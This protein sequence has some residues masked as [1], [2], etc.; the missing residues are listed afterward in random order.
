MLVGKPGHAACFGACH[1]PL[2]VA[3]ARG[4]KIVTGDRTKVCTAC[5][6]E[7]AARRA[8]RRQ[9]A[10]ALPAVQDRSRTSAS[11]LGHKQ[12]AQVACTQC[13]APSVEDAP[14]PH[15]RCAGCHDGS[16]PH[17]RW[18]RARAAT[19]RR[20]A[21]RSRPSSPRCTTRVT[22]I[23]LARHARASAARRTARRATPRSR[24]PTTASCLA[25]PSRTARRCHDG[26]AA[27]ATT[28]A[29]RRCHDRAGRAVHG[30]RAP[31][32]GSATT[33]RTPRRSQRARAARAIRCR[34]P[35]RSA[36]PATRRARA[37]TPMTSARASRR[38]AAR[39]TTRPSRGA[40]SIADRRSPERTE[41]G[42]TL[43]HEQARRRRAGAATCCAPQA[44]QLRPPRGH[45]ACTQLPPRD[46][47][48]GAAARRLR[49]CH[50]AGRAAAR[51]TA[52]RRRPW[53]VRARVRSRARI[54]ARRVH[55][56]SHRSRAAT[57]SSRSPVP[58][59]ADVRAVPRR[60]RP[61]SS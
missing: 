59:K 32:R 5:H 53:S 45:A 57:T 34:R 29:C 50:R 38:S 2:P 19:R 21:S 28:I 44:T 56:V 14:A 41:F 4:A 18:R 25:R 16:R 52:A 10:G 24:A 1:G 48:A 51:E 7:C 37:A 23:V 47:R 36:S 46:R 17:R 30:R 13:H 6:A 3:P 60:R 26:K 8:V 15:A 20:S 27:F 55:R 9:A 58:A 22:S 11:T 61:R 33:A 49:G 42:A 40:R 31:T 35:A 54:A 39:A 12:H 43:D